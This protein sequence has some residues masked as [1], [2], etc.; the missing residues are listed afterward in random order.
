M[1]KH[2]GGGDEEA[3]EEKGGDRRLGLPE[4]E[5]A[6]AGKKGVEELGAAYRFFLGVVAVQDVCR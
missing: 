6:G 4:V 2:A 1:E 3:V 5:I